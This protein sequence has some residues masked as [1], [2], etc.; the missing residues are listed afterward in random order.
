[1]MPPPRG[2]EIWEPR[3]RSRPIPAR[4]S[5][6]LLESPEPLPDAFWRPP[7]LTMAGTTPRSP[8]REI[9]RP[10]SKTED[11]VPAKDRF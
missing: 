1:M 7:G 11:G 3:T 4:F 10:D 2:F 9:P 6:I 5:R 8:E